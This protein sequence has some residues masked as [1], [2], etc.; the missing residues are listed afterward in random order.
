MEKP[1]LVTAISNRGPR[2]AD[3][4]KIWRIN[5]GKPSIPLP[6]ILLQNR[7]WCRLRAYI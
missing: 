4:E 6:S 7:C 5:R 2:S 3:N 1:R